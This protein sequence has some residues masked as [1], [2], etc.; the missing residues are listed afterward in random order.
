MRD[1]GLDEAMRSATGVDRAIL[2]PDIFGQS[3]GMASDIE[4]VECRRSK[5]YAQL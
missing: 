2:R 3:T 4:E 5:R 1:M